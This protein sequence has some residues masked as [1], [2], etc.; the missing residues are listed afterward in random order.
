MGN[1]SFNGYSFWWYRYVVAPIFGTFCFVIG[2]SVLFIISFGR[3][4]VRS[5][6]TFSENKTSYLEPWRVN[7]GVRT[8]WSADAALFIGMGLL[9]FS[10]LAFLAFCC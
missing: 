2:A 9:F 6:P 3:W 10:L 5:W 8:Y 1:I 7:N 4:R